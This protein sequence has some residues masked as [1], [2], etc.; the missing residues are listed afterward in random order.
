MKVKLQDFAR[1][2][3][4]TD[5]AIQKH[6]Q[7]HAEELAGHFERKGP[8]GTWLDDYA[9][10]FI[11][12]LMYET[13][14][15][16]MDTELVR[17]H[18]ELQDQYQLVSGQLV[19][20]QDR[21]AAMAGLEVRLAASEAQTSLLSKEV[22]DYKNQ[23]SEARQEAREDRRK[24]DTAHVTITELTKKLA[25]ET[26]AR[27]AAEADNVALKGRGLLARIFRRGE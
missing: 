10:E 26:A 21:L 4:V 22:A 12:G 13:P 11:S 20:A 5:R 23:A 3:G 17:K 19:Q 25:E 9:Q 27:K 2:K 6:I 7:N 1:E 8:N 14:T 24:L 18:Q 15:V 16:I